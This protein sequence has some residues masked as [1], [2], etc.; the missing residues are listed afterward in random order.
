M[1]GESFPATVFVTE[2]K[3]GRTVVVD[4]G[5]PEGERSGFAHPEVVLVALGLGGSPDADN[6][7]SWLTPDEATE[8]ASKLTLAAAMAKSGATGRES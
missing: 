1:S 3:P 6:A 4:L 2:D 5:V 8:I 7:W